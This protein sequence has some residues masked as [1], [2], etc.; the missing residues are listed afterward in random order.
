MSTRCGICSTTRP[1]LRAPVTAA[2]SGNAADLLRRQ[3]RRGIR[4]RTPANAPAIAQ[5]LLERGADPNAS[6]RLYGGGST[7]L[8]LL[9]TSIHPRKP[10]WTATSCA[11]S[12]D[13]ERRSGSTI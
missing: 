10:A 5:L 6:C 7:T 2:A 1:T 3:R 9:L 13:S 11:C 4:Q 12:R 8:G